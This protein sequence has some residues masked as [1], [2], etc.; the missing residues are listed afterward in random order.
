[1]PDAR[2]SLFRIA[3]SALDHFGANKALAKHARGLGVI[4]TL[5]HVRPFSGGAFAPNRHL[6]IE[7][8][9]LDLALTRARNAGFD[10]VTLDEALSRVRAGV[11]PR[12]FLHLTFDDGYRDVRDHAL[13]I[14]RRHGAPATLYIASDFADGH[15]RLWWLELEAGLARADRVEVDL[16]DGRKSVSCR[17]VDEKANAFKTI[18]R[19]L[20]QGPEERLRAETLKIAEAGGVD[21]SA[22]ARDLCM[23]WDEL[24]EVGADPLVEIGA[25]TV[26]H[27]M[28]ATHP[29]ETA[30]AEMAGS[31]QAIAE[32]LG[33]A[34]AHFAYPVGDLAAAGD[35][36]YA[37]AAELGFA[38]AVTTR[39]GH[40]TQA[41]AQT[42]TALPRVSLNGHFQTRAAV[43]AYL[44]G[45]PFALMA[46]AKRVLGR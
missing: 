12:P 20:R 25:H 31:W 32:R 41:H 9:F 21:A 15:A 19:A 14:L 39:P 11:S 22:F 13:P 2:T 26:S 17:T 6:E 30:R 4:L 44:S 24:A 46:A 38:S 40:L 29:P 34:P 1:M 45:A 3:F 10:F 43:D 8:T 36:E 23:R 33:A 42:P 35:R 37:L 7:P 16:G 18:L 27:P 28:L 5:H